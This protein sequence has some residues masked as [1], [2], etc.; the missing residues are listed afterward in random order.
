VGLGGQHHALTNL[1]QG[2]E[3]VPTVQKAGWVSGLVWTGAEILAPTGI[4]NP[5]KKGRKIYLKIN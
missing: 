2:K 1:P 5:S 3:A 4:R